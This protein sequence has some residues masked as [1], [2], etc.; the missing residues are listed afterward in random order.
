MDAIWKYYL[1]RFPWRFFVHQKKWGFSQIRR[2]FPIGISLCGPTRGTRSDG[3]LN[4][5]LLKR[6]YDENIPIIVEKYEFYIKKTDF[7]G[8]I[9]EL[10][11]ISI[12][13]KK[14]QAIID[15]QDLKS[16]TGLRLFLG[17]YNYYKKFIAK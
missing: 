7:I 15:W 17:F 13:L 10:G 5:L 9:I 8:F 11:Q 6:L 3:K 14:V 1:S 4:L 12:D 16:I 2:F